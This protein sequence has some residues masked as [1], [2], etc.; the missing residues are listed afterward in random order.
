MAIERNFGKRGSRTRATG[1]RERRARVLLVLGGVRTEADYFNWVKKMLA[2]SG[3]D[4]KIEGQG[5]DPESLVAHAVALKEKD[6]QAARRARDLANTYDAVW[7][8]TDVDEFVDHIK[9]IKQREPDG[10]EVAIT[11]PCFEAWLNMHHDDSAAPVS[12][13]EAQSKAKTLGVVEANNPKRVVISALTGRL[14]EATTTARRLAAR[15]SRN[16][17]EFPHDS[18]S[19]SVDQIVQYLLKRARAANPQMEVEL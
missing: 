3:L 6:E 5:W 19:T 9:R 4:I 16:G 15:H 13:F 2:T 7:V 18:P 10:V 14:E 11:N 8:V 1:M 17:T 12:R